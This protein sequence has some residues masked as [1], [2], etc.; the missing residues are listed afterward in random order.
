MRFHLNKITSDKLHII[1]KRQ[2]GI[3]QNDIRQNDKSI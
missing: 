1:R 2:N 3:R